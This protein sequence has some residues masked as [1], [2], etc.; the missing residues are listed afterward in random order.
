ME[1][2]SRFSNTWKSYSILKFNKNNETTLA[3]KKSNLSPEIQSDAGLGV[4]GGSQSSGTK[5]RDKTGQ[6]MTA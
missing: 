3:E 2:S 4:V 6:Y 5:L 1:F